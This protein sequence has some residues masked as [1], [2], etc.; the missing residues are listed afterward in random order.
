MFWTTWHSLRN[1]GWFRGFPAHLSLPACPSA[2]AYC[3]LAQGSRGWRSEPLSLDFLF[4]RPYAIVTHAG[5]SLEWF[6]Q[7]PFVSC[8]AWVE[9]GC[10]RRHFTNK[11]QQFQIKTLLPFL[12]NRFLV[13]ITSDPGSDF[14]SLQ[15]MAVCVLTPETLSQ[16]VRVVGV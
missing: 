12:F 5:P 16:P 15:H 11:L 7:L 8:G 10:G 6:R 2:A 4:I 1:S 9:W 14:R 13:R 3:L